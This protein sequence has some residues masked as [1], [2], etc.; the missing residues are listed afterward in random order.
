MSVIVLMSASGSPGVTT[1]SL[2]LALGWHRPALL[3]EADPTGGSAIA[4]GYLRGAVVP[5]EALIELALAGQDGR[6]L[7]EVLPR[8]SQGLPGSTVRWVPGSRSHEQARTLLGLWEPLTAALCCLEDTGQDVIVD[9]GRLGLYGSPEPL[10]YAADLALLVSRTD[11]VSLSAARSWAHTLKDRFA[12]AGASGSLG[13]LLVGEHRPFTAREVASVLEV[14]VT[15]A[16]AWDPQSA[17]VL[18]AGAE[19]PPSGWA[20]RLAGRSGWDDTDLLRSLRAARSAITA[21]VRANQDQ[22]A[23]PAAGRPTP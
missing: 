22:I 18:A 1:S 13:L 4:A 2:G 12:R 9:A 23:Q 19:P 10:I 3:V 20:H 14:P 6:D 8:V 16:L 11:L 21:R 17:A 15:A 7:I 5:A